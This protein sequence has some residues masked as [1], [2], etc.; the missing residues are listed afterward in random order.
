MKQRVHIASVVYLALVPDLGQV[1]GHHL[2]VLKL[3]Q[4]F[5]ELLSGV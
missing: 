1:V 2:D 4:L 3:P 5:N